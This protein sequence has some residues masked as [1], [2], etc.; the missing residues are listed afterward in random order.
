[1]KF[2]TLADAHAYIRRHSEAFRAR[3]SAVRTRYWSMDEWR[4]V[5][6]WTVVLR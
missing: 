1:M 3:L 2:S 6:C 4:W 5:E